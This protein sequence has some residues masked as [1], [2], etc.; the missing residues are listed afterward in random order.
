[1]NF[2]HT[3]TTPN[4]TPL[5]L[6]L[7]K[8]VVVVVVE[9]AFILLKMVIDWSVPDTPEWVRRQQIAAAGLQ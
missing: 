4:P 9:H 3:H 8:V 5:S 1:M 2:L 7:F 6:S